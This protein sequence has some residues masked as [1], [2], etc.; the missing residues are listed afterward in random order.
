MPPF[1]PFQGRWTNSGIR[2]PLP[3]EYVQTP[4]HGKPVEIN[5]Y[6]YN[7]VCIVREL[8]K[9]QGE[10]EKAARLDVLSEKIKKSFLKKFT[11]PDGTLYDVLPENGEPDD[12]SKQVRCN[13]IF[14]LQYS[15]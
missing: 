11:K 6:W 7:A 10:E 5:A 2:R 13:E 12:A 14:A 4:R 8:L 3:A 1:L 9:K 15:I